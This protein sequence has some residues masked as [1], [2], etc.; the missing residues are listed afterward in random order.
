MIE[1]AD[2]VVDE[3]TRLTARIAHVESRILDRQQRIGCHAVSCRHGIA[4]GMTS[5]PVLLS[6]AGMGFAIGTLTRRQSPTSTG[7]RAEDIPRA[8]GLLDPILKSLTFILDLLPA[9]R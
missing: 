7:R 8:R 2:G 3:P 6:A 1:A 5:V 9:R 4:S